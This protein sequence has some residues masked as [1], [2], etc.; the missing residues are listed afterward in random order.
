MDRMI[1][2]LEKKLGRYAIQKLPLV[3]IVCY[4]VGYLIQMIN[5]SIIYT[6]SLN[7]YAIVHGQF[8]RLFTWVLIPPENSNILFTLIMLYFYYS[9][10]NTLERVWGT[11]YFNYYIFSGLLFAVLGAFGVYGYS[12]LFEQDTM[13]MVNQM[14]TLNL[15]ME[16]PWAWGGDYYFLKMS[17]R[18]STYYINMALFLA[19][20]CTFPDMQVLFMFIIPVKVKYLGI[21]YAFLL[22]SD[23]I[24]M[25]NGGIPLAI[26]LFTVGN[27]LL[28][29]ILF[30]FSIRNGRVSMKQKRRQRE[31]QRKV[32]PAKMRIS[33]HK[34]AICGRTQDEYPELEF[35]FC[36]KCE[37]NY[38]YCQDHLFTHKHFTSEK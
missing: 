3:L 6:L 26:A 35:R 20:A 2:F 29:F 22:V 23:I 34:C 33:K 10:G 4:A 27:S 17:L 37:G 13:A 24:Y 32:Q 30:F 18:F 7:P 14:N 5:P 19:Y 28:N 31:F 38:E 9:I 36:S 8:W 15:H 16:C 12:I 11:F 25:V 21:L 1:R